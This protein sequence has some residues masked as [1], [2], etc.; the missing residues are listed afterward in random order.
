VIV[1]G[2]PNSSNSVRL[3]EVARDAGAPAAYL[4][5]D[6]GEVDEIWLDGVT[7][8]GVTS[9]ASVPGILVQD[10]RSLELPAA[11]SMRGIWEK[12]QQDTS[13]EW[14]RRL[15][16]ELRSYLNTAADEAALVRTRRV[17]PFGKASELRPVATAARPVS[18]EGLHDP[19]LD[20]RHDVAVY[21]QILEDWLYEGIKRQLMDT[22]RYGTTIRLTH[23][24]N[25][26]QLLALAESL[27]S[28]PPAW[29]F[30][31]SAAAPAC[32]DGK[33]WSAFLA[34]RTA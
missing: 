10:V 8:V 23:Q 28:P 3:V 31:R 11:R 15:R 25:P 12:L 27:P 5:D 1:V 4:V 34:A 2:S 17:N 18:A 32:G 30:T 22:D 16:T 6:A 29:H 24:E 19:D 9:G 7:T 33:L 13:L 21:L 26:N 14:R 20:R